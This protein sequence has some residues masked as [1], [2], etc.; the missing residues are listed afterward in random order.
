MR[1]MVEGFL[2]TLK[3]PST[4]LCAVPLPGKCRGGIKN[5]IHRNPWRPSGAAFMRILP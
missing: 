3:S 1:S 2:P 5:V 4:A